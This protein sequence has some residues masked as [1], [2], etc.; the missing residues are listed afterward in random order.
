MAEIESLTIVGA[1]RDPNK[2]G[3]QVL[4]KAIREGKPFYA[5]NPNGKVITVE[6][7]NDVRQDVRPYESIDDIP[8]TTSHAFFYIPRDKIT[9]EHAAQCE[10]KGIPEIVIP[11]RSDGVFDP[12]SIT[13]IQELFKKHHYEKEDIVFDACYIRGM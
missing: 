2:Y 13:R 10:R 8:S 6:L 11:P 1:S 3:H 9:E 12:E 7:E 4:Q 5:V